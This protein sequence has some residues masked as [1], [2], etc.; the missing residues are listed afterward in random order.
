MLIFFRQEFCNLLF[1]LFVQFFLVT[2]LS[3]YPLPLKS[4]SIW[5]TC[6]SQKNFS[7]SFSSNLFKNSNL[8]AKKLEEASKILAQERYTQAI[9]LKNLSLSSKEKELLSLELEKLQE[10]EQELLGYSENFWN[11]QEEKLHFNYLE[12]KILKEYFLSKRQIYN[13]L[14]RR[15]MEVIFSEITQINL[16]TFQ[17]IYLSSLKLEYQ[18]LSNLR[19]EIREIILTQIFGS[20]KSN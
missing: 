16:E 8:A 13:L 1:L 20:E 11:Y 7:F 2:S 18:M 17:N 4:N 15:T 3:A 9:C 10:L 5:K 6:I 14:F 19:P 12:S